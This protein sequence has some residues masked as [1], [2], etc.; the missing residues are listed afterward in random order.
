VSKKPDCV[1]AYR[2]LGEILFNRSKFA[3]SAQ[4]YAKYIEKAQYTPEEKERYAYSLFFSQE[5]DKAKEIISQ[6]SK[7]DPN[8]YIMLRLLAY[9]HYQKEEYT[10][11]VEAFKNF[12]NQIPENKV[13]NFDIEYY[14]R[15]LEKAKMDSLAAIQYWNTFNRDTTR[16]NL[17]DDAARCYTR[18]K[19][20]DKAA[21]TSQKSFDLKD[22]DKLQASDYQKFGTAYYFAGTDMR[23]IDTIAKKGY[24]IKADTLFGSVVSINPK[25]TPAYLMRARTNANLNP[26][27]TPSEISKLNYDKALALMIAAPDKDKYKKDMIEVYL[28][29]SFYYIQNEKFDVAKDYCNK[30]LE[31][32]PNDKRAPVILE[33]LNNLKNK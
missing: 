29:S 1:V 27:N 32:D 13:L 10:Q 23:N 4:N 26:P 2:E 22:K 16:T 9:T 20:F 33:Q 31:L 28:Y 8:N 30:I 12:F 7:G 18:Y 19:A 5:Y 11:G 14:A 21:L 6:L 25:A 3:E 17:L 24:L 15:T